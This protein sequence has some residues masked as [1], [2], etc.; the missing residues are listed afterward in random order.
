M[1]VV[2]ELFYVLE[3]F[4]HKLIYVNLSCAY[5]ILKII[6]N[7]SA[8]DDDDFMDM[9]GKSVAIGSRPRKEAL[10]LFTPNVDATF[11]LPSC[12][13]AIL[14]LVFLYTPWQF[15]AL[16]C[17]THMLLFLPCHPM[18]YLITAPI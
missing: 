5:F 1:I 15:L 14:L 3:T 16:I 13:M 10:M 11:Y 4:C 9:R 12:F 7:G 6:R 17:T 18:I 2:T 8:N